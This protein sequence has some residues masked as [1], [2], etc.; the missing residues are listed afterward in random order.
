VIVLA[1]IN[2]FL[3]ALVWFIPWWVMDFHSNCSEGE[4]VHYI[5]DLNVGVCQVGSQAEFD[6]SNC[7]HWDD[8]ASWEEIDS[9]AGSDTAEYATTVFPHVIR[10]RGAYSGTIFCVLYV[11]LFAL[12]R[13]QHAYKCQYL[14]TLISLLYVLLILAMQVISGD[15]D[16]VS[17]EVWKAV[18]GCQHGSSV[19]Y[20][21]QYGV[22]IAQ[23][24]GILT[25]LVVAF[26]NRIVCL[27]LVAARDGMSSSSSFS[28]SFYQS[29]SALHSAAS[30]SLPKDGPMDPHH[31]AN[32][33]GWQISYHDIPPPAPPLVRPSVSKDI[34]SPS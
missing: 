34:E 6:H 12:C 18:T 7:I 24:F 21:A 33:S 28:L 32:Q 9:I 11:S 31:T 16:V 8:K 4:S 13:P 19:P 15:N 20:V 10:L 17:K 25:A 14:I 1:A 30:T 2:I 23:L 5:I 27:H 22:L 26:P 3:T 29:T